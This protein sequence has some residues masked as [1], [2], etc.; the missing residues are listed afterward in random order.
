[1]RAPSTLPRHPVPA[2]FRA[3]GFA[4][5]HT[6]AKGASGVFGGWTVVSAKREGSIS[7]VRRCVYR[8]RRTG[9]R[10]VSV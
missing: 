5:A 7:R 8:G 2:L 1:M 9:W 4:Y 3:R 6:L 10:Y